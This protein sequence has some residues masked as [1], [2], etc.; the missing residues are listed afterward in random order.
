MKMNSQSRREFLQKSAM[1]AA[2]FTIVG[3]IRATED[4]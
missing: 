4:K 1:A 3:G 2:A